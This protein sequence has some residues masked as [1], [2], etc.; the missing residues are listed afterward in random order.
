MFVVGI[1]TV[2]LFSYLGDE[3]ANAAARLATFLAMIPVQILCVQMVIGKRFG[4]LKLTLL[5]SSADTA[6]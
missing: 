5:E 6:V 3:G 4:K 1:T 2:M